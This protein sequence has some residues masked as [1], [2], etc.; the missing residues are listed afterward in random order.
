MPKAKTRRVVKVSTKGGV[1]DTAIVTWFREF[2]GLKQQLEQIG[3]RQD[4]V[5]SR[6][7]EAVVARGYTDSEG[8]GWF[9][10]PE[11]IEGY[12]KLKL[13]RRVRER[14]D[15][16]AA[17]ALVRERGL[18][19]KCVKMVPTLDHDAL[20]GAVYDGDIT[21]AEFQAFIKKSESFA[22]VPRA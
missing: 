2:V 12:S 1:T 17:M 22:F 13:E 16:D 10:L 9:D 3:S 18:E 4:E 14:F 6:L 7:K 19:K 8:H 5:K 11:E 20:A 21:E 15:D